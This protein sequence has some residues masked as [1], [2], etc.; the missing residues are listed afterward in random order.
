MLTRFR[1]MVWMNLALGIMPNDTVAMIAAKYP[2]FPS[3]L[4]IDVA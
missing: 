4:A 1:I 2:R 3:R